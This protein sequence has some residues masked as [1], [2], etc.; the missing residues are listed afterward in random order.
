MIT[1]VG[2]SHIYE[3]LPHKQLG[4]FY[5]GART[6]HQLSNHHDLHA[7]QVFPILRKS[8]VVFFLGEIDCRIHIYNKAMKNS[9]SISSCIE[10]TVVRYV[11]YLKKIK[12]EFE[13]DLAVMSV[14][15]AGTQLNAYNYEFYADAATQKSITMSF[16]AALESYSNLCKIKYINIFKM[17]V[18]ANN[19]R[20][21]TVVKDVCHC[22]YSAEIVSEILKAFEQR[23]QEGIPIRMCVTKE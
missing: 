5:L 11:E 6:A 3:F 13:L 17:L 16:N 2:D 8:G 20:L 10:N 23:Q 21:A 1:V 18:D 12:D 22:Y 7:R 14:V 19:D 15:P 4:I 9:V